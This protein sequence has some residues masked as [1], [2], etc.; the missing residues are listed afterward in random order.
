VTKNRYVLL[1]AVG[2]T[3]VLAFCFYTFWA[4]FEWPHGMGATFAAIIAETVSFG[5][6][7]FLAIFIGLAYTRKS[8][9]PPNHPRI[10]HLRIAGKYR[11]V[12]KFG[13]AGISP[14]RLT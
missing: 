12:G 1:A 3:L 5:I 2:S 13:E 11:A 14:L 7:P 8:L 6:A 4:V 9:R 10:E